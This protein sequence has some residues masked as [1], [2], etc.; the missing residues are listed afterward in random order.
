MLKDQLALGRPDNVQIVF[1]RKVTRRTPGRFRT[2]VMNDGVEPQLQ[3]HY[4]HSK[5]KQYLKEGRALRTETTINDPNDF[6]VGRTLNAENWLALTRIGH[7]VN[8]RRSPL[9]S[10]RATAR[11]TRQRLSVSCRRP[12][13]TAYPHPACESASPA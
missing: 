4:K 6:G 5:V 12:S 2:R 7:E 8:E 13:R 1:A 10:R 11:P 9:S 3:A